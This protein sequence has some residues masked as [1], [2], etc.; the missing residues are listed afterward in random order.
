M[1][2]AATANG[3]GSLKP[4]SLEHRKDPEKPD[5]QLSHKM[6]DDEVSSSQEAFKSE[7]SFDS[8]TE[9]GTLEIFTILK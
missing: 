4:P 3:F 9:K 5:S 8:K 1:P 7:G 6:K 2:R